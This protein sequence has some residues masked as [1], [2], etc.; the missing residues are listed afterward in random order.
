MNGGYCNTFL[1]FQ[2][3]IIG[4]FGGFPDMAVHSLVMGEGFCTHLSREQEKDILPPA[5]EVPRPSAP[6]PT[7]F[8]VILEQHA[9]Y[10]HE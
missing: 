3:L 5:G 9:A 10:W 7:V 6:L 4:T 1:L 8:P 2:W